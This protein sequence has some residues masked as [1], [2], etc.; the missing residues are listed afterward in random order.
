MPKYHNDNKQFKV[1]TLE[2]LNLLIASSTPNLALKLRI[3]TKG[4]R[5]IEVVQL[6]PDHIDTDRKT[7]TP[8]TA[9][10]GRPRTIPIDE[11]LNE[12]IKAHIQTN[13]IQPKE[14][15]FPIDPHSYCTTY[16]RTRNKLAKKLNDP[17][18]LK[19]RLYDF[20]HY[21]G[22]MTMLKT[23]SV[24]FTAN[25]LGHKEWKNTQVYVDMVAV[26]N[27]IDEEYYTAVAETPEQARK[28]IEQGFQKAD[29]WEKAHIYRKR[30]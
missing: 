30:K 7:I 2:K 1:P 26:L 4:L 3:S 14:K 15:L 20:R 16:C 8:K 11:P 12:A 28:L 21:F 9:K 10:N 17:T 24:P 23:G 22:T 27:Q 29:E 18:L 6:T 25:Q 13:N 5:P 19:I